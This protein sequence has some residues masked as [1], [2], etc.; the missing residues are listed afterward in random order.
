MPKRFRKCRAISEMLPPAK[1][2][3]TPVLAMASISSPKAASSLRVNCSS[4]CALCSSTVPLVSE[5]DASR[6]QVSTSTLACC[7]CSTSFCG[8]FCSTMPGIM[9]VCAMLPPKRRAVR[10]LST[11]SFGVAGAGGSV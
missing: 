2:T 7:T 11:S 1:M 6:P 9:C 4:S 10:M 8:R 5:L 3:F